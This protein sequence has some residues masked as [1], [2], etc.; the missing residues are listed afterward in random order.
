MTSIV[1]TGMEVFLETL[2]LL[3]NITLLLVHNLYHLCQQYLG[4][5]MST[6]AYK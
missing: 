1:M 3:V 6:V 5:K 2:S 4:Q